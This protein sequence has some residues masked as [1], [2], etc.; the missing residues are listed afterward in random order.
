MP[1]AD[2]YK[3]VDELSGYAR[4]AAAGLPLPPGLDGDAAKRLLRS[5]KLPEPSLES[6]NAIADMAAKVPSFISGMK[7]PFGGSSSGGGSK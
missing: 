4:A 2:P 5:M 1:V 6:L 7:P 3:M